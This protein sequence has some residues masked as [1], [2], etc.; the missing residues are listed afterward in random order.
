MTNIINDARL[1]GGIAALTAEIPQGE[2]YPHT[3]V[4]GLNLLASSAITLHRSSRVSSINAMT[5]PASDFQGFTDF[6]VGGDPVQSM[7]L[8]M[9]F[10]ASGDTSYQ[11]TS[12]AVISAIQYIEVVGNDG[13]TSLINLQ[14]GHIQ[15]ALSDR[16]TNSFKSILKAIQGGDEGNG[17][18]VTAAAGFS[19]YLPINTFISDNSIMPAALVSNGLTVRVW[20]ANTNDLKT[21][22]LSLASASMVVGSWAW[23]QSIRQKLQ[24]TYMKPNALVWRFH[25]PRFQKSTEVITPSQT[26]N[27]RLSGVNGLITSMTVIVRV[28]GLPVV[29]SKLGLVSPSGENLNGGSLI[30]AGFTDIMRAENDRHFP[31]GTQVFDAESAFRMPISTAADERAEGQVTAYVPMSNAHQLQIVLASIDDDAAVSASVEVLY[32][33]LA[34]FSV[35]KGIASI[36]NS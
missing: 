13:S 18:T 1:R 30:D 26:F 9:D 19:S 24:A 20:W 36:Q 22:G 25:Q 6:R 35:Q 11:L 12:D 14:P 8:K 29:I 23:D 32:T 16:P 34:T 7:S 2:T 31:D 10:T 5:A 33:S 4:G 28:G 27:L 17:A 15:Q 3:M 21:A